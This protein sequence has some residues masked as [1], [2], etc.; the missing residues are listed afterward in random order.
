MKEAVKSLIEDAVWKIVSKLEKKGWNFGYDGG[1]CPSRKDVAPEFLSACVVEF[2]PLLDNSE[3]L[4]RHLTKLAAEIE[5][6]QAEYG[7]LINALSDTEN[8]KRS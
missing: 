6:K 8:D 4:Q 7:A 5:G 1:D 2:G 3:M